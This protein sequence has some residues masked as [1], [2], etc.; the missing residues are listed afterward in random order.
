MYLYVKMQ[1]Q[2]Y[3]NCLCIRAS[4]V[5]ALLWFC[6]MYVSTVY[7]LAYIKSSA[8]G[9]KEIWYAAYLF[10]PFDMDHFQSIGA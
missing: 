2:S 9:Q 3:C 1:E 8:I 10:T 5:R 6:K 7:L 4:Q